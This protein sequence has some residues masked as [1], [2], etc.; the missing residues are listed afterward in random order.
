[1]IEIRPNFNANKHK[2]T[3]WVGRVVKMETNP[4]FNSTQLK[5]KIWPTLK[6]TKLET[7]YMLKSA[8]RKAFTIMH[9]YKP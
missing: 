8:K 3:S 5:L 9:S 4:W 7:C 2:Q 1:M 6:H